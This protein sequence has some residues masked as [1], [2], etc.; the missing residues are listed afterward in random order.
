M[1]M[2]YQPGMY[3]SDDHEALRKELIA[4][5]VMFKTLNLIEF[6]DAVVMENSDTLDFH[7]RRPKQHTLPAF[8]I[9]E[10]AHAEPQVMGWYNKGYSMDKYRA[11]L[12]IDD[13]A[14]VRLDETIQWNYSMEGIARGMAQA[15]DNEILSTLYRGAGVTESAGT[16]WNNDAADPVGDV[17]TII[18]SI[19]EQDDTNIDESEL[20]QIVVYYP[21]KLFGHIRLPTMF[22]NPTAGATATQGRLMF[23]SPLDWTT[24][25]IGW[26]FKSSQKLNSLNQAIAIIKG[27]NTATHYSYTG[28]KIPTVEQSRSAREG[29]DEWWIT[30]Y[31][32]TIAHDQ[33]FDVQDRNFRIM[34]ISNVSS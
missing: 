9:T 29:S 28:N 33:S 16:A 31:Y 25:K 6:S 15:R 18:E 27:P 24:Q 17:A 1:E 34:L 3:T 5:R 4:K 20:N 30:Q 14:R 32:K 22:M 13:E 19:F 8:K 23:E 21:R 2:T 7:V 11:A 26:T 12:Q 10:G